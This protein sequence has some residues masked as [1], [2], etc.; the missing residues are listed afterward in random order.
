MKLYRLMKAADDG[1]PAIGTKFGMLGVRPKDAGNS[2]KRFDVPVSSPDDIVQPGMGGLSV[3]SDP[4]ALK[5]PDDEFHLWVIES[6]QLSPGLRVEEAGPPHH[7]IEVATDTTLAEM[8][9][10]LAET[11][12]NWKRVE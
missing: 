3:N 5:A 4:N 2:K 8:Q 9:R 1:L 12:E 10:Q 7:V 6:E 11:R